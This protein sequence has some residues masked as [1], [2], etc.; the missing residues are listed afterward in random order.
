MP[1]GSGPTVSV[2]TPSSPF[3]ISCVAFFRIGCNSPLLSVTFSAFG[4]RREHVTLP[5]S[6]T[7]GETRGCRCWAE[8]A[9][10]HRMRTNDAGTV[11]R[12]R[13]PPGTTEPGGIVVPHACGVRHDA[14]GRMRCLVAYPLRGP[15]TLHD[16][17]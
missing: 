17:R 2:Q 1:G 8:A 9:A 5:S 7:F 3:V 12:M 10:T 11:E 13:D 6:P 16:A 14:V 15:R 4:A